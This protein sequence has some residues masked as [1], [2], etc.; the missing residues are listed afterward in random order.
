MG[1]WD[2]ALSSSKELSLKMGWWDGVL[3]FKRTVA[4]D[5]VVGCCRIYQWD[6]L[7]AWEVLQLQLHTLIG[8]LQGLRVGL[9]VRKRCGAVRVKQVIFLVHFEGFGEILPRLIIFALLFDEVPAVTFTAGKSNEVL[10]ATRLK[11]TRPVSPR[12]SRSESP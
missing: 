10:R 9:S 7:Q 4:G 2:G 8:V 5:G 3:F 1:W 12:G 11:S 6:T